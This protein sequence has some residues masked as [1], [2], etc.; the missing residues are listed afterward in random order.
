[1]T[2]RSSWPIRPTLGSQHQYQYFELLECIL[3]ATASNTSTILQTKKLTLGTP[4]A[5]TLPPHMG[6]IN[7]NASSKLLYLPLRC[8]N[9]LFTAL[10][11]CRAS[12]NFISEDLVN[13]IGTVTH[14]KVN[15]MPIWLADQYVMTL[16][17]S[18]TLPIRFTPYHICN[19]VFYIV[20]TL[21]HGVFLGMK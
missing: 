9:S 2:I 5:E 17:H 10:L 11:D 12:H 13:Q 8:F 6:W 16:D 7:T 15:P 20:P 3:T 21:P 1:M 14:I 4:V 19:I 18:V